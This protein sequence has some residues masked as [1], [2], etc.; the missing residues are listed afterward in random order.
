M[1]ISDIEQRI[2]AKLDNFDSK[3][4]DLCERMVRVETNLSNHLE[5]QQRKFNR[6]TLVFGI[7][8]SVVGLV[9]AIK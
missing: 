8:I 5:S 1:P 6:T 9:V 4:D 7:I 3:L 2:F